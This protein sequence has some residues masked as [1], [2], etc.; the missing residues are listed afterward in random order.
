MSDDEPNCFE[1]CP[2]KDCN[3][4]KKPFAAPDQAAVRVKLQQHLR[5]IHS[6]FVSQEKKERKQRHKK[7]YE[8]DQDGEDAFVIT[9]T[10]KKVKTMIAIEDNKNDVRG[11]EDLA[12]P[13]RVVFESLIAT[14]NSLRSANADDVQIVAVLNSHSQIHDGNLNSLRQIAEMVSGKIEAQIGTLSDQA[15]SAR[16]EFVSHYGNFTENELG[17][18]HYGENLHFQD[19]DRAIEF[20][21]FFLKVLLLWKEEKDPKFVTLKGVKQYLV[22]RYITLKASVETSSILTRPLTPPLNG[23]EN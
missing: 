19:L 18:L 23:T 8:E 17:S 20:T 3:R 6:H 11:K 2:Y 16:N 22:N 4:Y 13:N 12:D 5:T 14:A 7:K 21:N 15:V 10:L 9:P 1:Y